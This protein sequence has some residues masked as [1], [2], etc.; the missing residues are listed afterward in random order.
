MS[1]DLIQVVEEVVVDGNASLLDTLDTTV[2]ES[3]LSYVM[4]FYCFMCFG[5]V[6]KL[7]SRLFSLF[8][9]LFAFAFLLK[10]FSFVCTH[11]IGT[12][13]FLLF[14]S[15]PFLTCLYSKWEREH[16][17]L[18]L[19]KAKKSSEAH[20]KMLADAKNDM[21]EFYK[22]REKR[23]DARKKQNMYVITHHLTFHHMSITFFFSFTRYFPIRYNQCLVLLSK[24]SLPDKRRL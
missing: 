20:K 12:M 8:A 9:N 23:V 22:E 17:D 13:L 24:S 14:F 16:A 10:M 1:A 4:C 6:L 3:P 15:L 21:D 11:F 2:E 5:L 18:L 7:S 19:E